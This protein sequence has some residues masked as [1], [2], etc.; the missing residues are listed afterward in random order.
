MT[1]KKANRLIKSNSPYLL[2]HAYNPVEWFPW[3]KEAHKISKET[4]KPI[5]LS[6]GYSSC[7]WCHVMERESFENETIARAMNEKFICIKVDREERP[8][9]DQI[10]MEAVQA[11]GGHGGWPLTIF[12]TPELKP[13]Y[14]GTYFPPENFL[15]LLE[16]VSSVYANNKA[17]MDSSANQI[18]TALT[19]SELDKFRLRYNDEV[20]TLKLQKM[21][22]NL[23][24][25]FDKEFGG[26][27]RAPKFPM[28]GTWKFLSHFAFIF[29]NNEALHHFF[30]TLDKISDGGIYDQAGGGFARYST[31]RKWHV[32]HFEKMLYDNGQLMSLYAIAYSLSQIDRYKEILY[33]T[34][35]WLSREMTH[36][37]GGFYSALDA[38]SEGVEGKFYVWKWEE[39]ER[40]AN[41]NTNKF[42][43]F[44][45]V[46]P[47]GNWEGTNILLRN[48]GV[49]KEDQE[50]I[51]EFKSRLLKERN[52]RIRPG[53][54]DKILAGWNALMSSGLLDAYDAT[55]DEVFLQHAVKN[56]TFLMNELFID[57]KLF[58]SWKDG[59]PGTAGFLEDYSCAIE[60][61][62]KLY[63][64]TF[65]RKWLD[66]ALQL[67]KIAYEKFYDPAD[68][69]FY[70]S[71][72]SSD[73]IAR[74]KEILDNV[75][76]ASNSI[77][78]NA[79]FKLGALMGDGKYIALAKKMTF[80]LIDLMESETEYTS[81]WALLYS[82]LVYPT[83]EVALVG[84]DFEKLGKAVRKEYFPNKVIAGTKAKSQIPLLANRETS[85]KNS[86]IYVCQN[87]A[88]QLPV[89]NPDEALE[90]MKDNL[91]IIK[92]RS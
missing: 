90:Q 41:K 83:S 5:L 46:I 13:I 74:K 15:V 57:G 51:E 53:L 27:S 73:L 33:E 31:D 8:D 12:L 54:D 77:M 47:E 17:E 70:F 19:G 32:P 24:S 6:I 30:F 1:N 43:A 85:S 40:I 9:I 50:E 72:Q 68:G 63:Q 22:Q 21:Y 81:N 25:K 58:R 23:S 14:G 49:P 42:A 67:V 82:Y 71:E 64:S 37:S 78:A 86:M 79:L 29:K 80:S 89:T 36:G 65:T 38:D 20:S 69:F 92:Q 62:L 10:Y 66:F 3:D 60:M 48:Q 55:G 2:Q 16:K 88:C 7:H 28:P 87:H 56:G 4:G 84:K 61:Y 18:A 26:M 39:F 75:I 76:P 52:N 44:F 35:A 11:M 91:R 59:K 45:G 34:L